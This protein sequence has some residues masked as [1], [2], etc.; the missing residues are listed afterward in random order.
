MTLGAEPRQRQQISMQLE[1]RKVSEQKYAVALTIGDCRD[2]SEHRTQTF[3]ACG[4][5]EHSEIAESEPQHVLI[6]AMRGEVDREFILEG[7]LREGAALDRHGGAIGFEKEIG[8]AIGGWKVQRKDGIRCDRYG[9][10]FS[11]L[12]NS[13]IEGPGR[14]CLPPYW[15]QCRAQLAVAHELKVST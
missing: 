5:G 2:D 11:I 15:W 7:G 1:G 10:V 12:R 14:G 6:G 3:G 9:L 4:D 8:S 13:G